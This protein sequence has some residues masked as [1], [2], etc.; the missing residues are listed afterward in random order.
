MTESTPTPP[1]APTRPVR[2]PLGL[3]AGSVRSLLALSILGMLAVIT[4]TH[5]QAEVGLLMVYLIYLSFIVL[6]HFFAAHGNTIG[7]TGPSPLG[8]PTGT[9]RLLLILGFAGLAV[10][11]AFHQSEV[12]EVPQAPATLP[13]V[14]IGSFIGGT[15][16]S[17]AVRRPLAR[18]AGV[19]FWYE[20]F[21]AWLALISM[22]GL[23]AE[24]VLRLVINPGLPPEKQ[25]TL[26]TWEL[27]FAGVIGFYFGARS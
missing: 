8:L 4:F 21:L 22:I 3:P 19:P 24:V 23:V 15:M 1:A 12:A 5:K 18:G 26:G 2:H 16:L 14:L 20:D 17:L 9:M 25:L 13:L 11:Y 6:A 7:H 10:Y 27:G